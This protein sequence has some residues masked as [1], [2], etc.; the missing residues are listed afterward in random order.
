M[1]KKYRLE[2]VRSVK[3]D[4]RKISKENLPEIIKKIRQLESNPRPTGA[5]RIKG[6]HSENIFRIR[7]A[8]YRIVYEIKEDVLIVLVIKVGHRKD[9]YR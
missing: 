5:I 3:K 6:T 2:I 8:N 9:V 4:L 1:P 7:H